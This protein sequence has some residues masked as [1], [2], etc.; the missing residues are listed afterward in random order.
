MKFRI[1]AQFNCVFFLHFIFG[2]S[3]LPHHSYFCQ[4]DFCR[5]NTF[6][7]VFFFLFSV[8]AWVNCLTDRINSHSS[9]KQRKTTTT[10]KKYLIALK[11]ATLHPIFKLLTATKNKICNN[12]WIINKFD[13]LSSDLFVCLHFSFFQFFFFVRRGKWN[14]HFSNILQKNQFQFS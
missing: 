1:K 3:L 4:I 13:Q 5:L 12:I 7:I 8:V 14:E 11:I 10:L 9:W 6:F 2:Y